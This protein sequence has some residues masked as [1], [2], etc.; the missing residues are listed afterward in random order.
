MS[1]SSP[2]PGSP[3]WPLIGAGRDADVYALGPDRVLR[4]YRRGGDVT[5]EAVVMRHL[6][7][8]GYPVPIV[9]RAE[10]ADLEMERLVG[11]TMLAELVSGSLD[12]ADAAAVVLDLHDR[13]HTL[14]GLGGASVCLV[15]LDLHPDN[16]VLASRGPVVIDWR[17]ARDG[18]ADLDLATTAVIFAA[19]AVCTDGPFKAWSGQACAFTEA[20]VALAADRVLSG[21]AEAVR[22]RE[23][24]PNLDPGERQ[25]VLAG[26][27][28]LRTMMR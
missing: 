24:N 19:V 26:A 6:G 5:H 22:I 17:D 1:G 16:V 20:F 21:L 27:D 10:G 7:A 18:C 11:P 28:L 2:Q 8:L 14:P 4:R 3:P 25:D 23:A 13:L 12:V 9:H 15:H